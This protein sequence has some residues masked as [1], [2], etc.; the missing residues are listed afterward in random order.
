[1]IDAQTRTDLSFRVSGKISER[2]VNVGDHV[3]TGQVLARLDP[4]EQQA[5]L[6]A[7]KAGV[8]SGDALC[9]RRRPLSNA[10]RSF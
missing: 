2:L 10:R 1:M 7:A 3:V 8:A 9:A 4:D 5:E 6:A